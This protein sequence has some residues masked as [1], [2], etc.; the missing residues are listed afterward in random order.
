MIGTQSV[1]LSASENE[2]VAFVWNTTSVSYCY[3][4]YNI[5]AFADISPEIDS[6]MTNN[7][8][9]S[10]TKVAVRILG[11]LNGAG[12]VDILDAIEFANYFGLQKGEAGW[13]PDADMNQ[14][15]V[16]NILDAIIIA[17]HFGENGSS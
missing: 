6:N 9:Q 1:T 4:G 2:T 5:T 8:L 13:N 7:V 12:K 3:S 10:P 11:D 15:G 17:E 14:D 16:T